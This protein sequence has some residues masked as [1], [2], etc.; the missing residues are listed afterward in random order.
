MLYKSLKYYKYIILI[1]YNR[2]DFTCLDHFHTSHY[3]TQHFHLFSAQRQGH[4]SLLQVPCR[5]D[6]F[7]SF[8][9]LT[10]SQIWWISS[11]FSPS[12]FPSPSSGL[13]Q[14]YASFLLGHHVQ[15]LPV[16]LN[17]Y[18]ILSSSSWAFSS[19]VAHTYSI[20]SCPLTWLLYFSYGSSRKHVKDRTFSFSLLHLLHHLR[21]P[22][23]PNLCPP[24]FF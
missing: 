16:H 14:F 20:L 15:T 1:V 18:L 3:F 5:P 2:P 13:N 6:S 9:W 4:I 23:H 19:S 24:A 7:S 22:Q 10:F 12:F 21:T 11:T 17:T 8:S